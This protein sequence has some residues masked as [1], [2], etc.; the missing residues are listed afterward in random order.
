MTVATLRISQASE[1]LRLPMTTF[2]DCPNPSWKAS[3][4]SNMY[5]VAAFLDVEKAFDNVWH[6]VLSLTFPPKWHVGSLTL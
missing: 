4:E 1:E 2:L 5:V 6:N 3:T